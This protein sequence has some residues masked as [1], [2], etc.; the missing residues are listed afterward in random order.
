MVG[1]HALAFHAKPRFTKDLDVLVEATEENARRVLSALA[2]F[3]FGSVDLSVEDL[4]VPGK[5]VQ[6]GYPPNRIDLLTSIA[7]VDFAEAWAGRA[8]GRY[9]DAEVHY[10]GRAE[11]IRNKRAAARPQDL[12]DLS[13]LEA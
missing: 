9:G 13:W 8:M 1:A 11:L 7:G 6:L 4:A 3:G 5:V 10:L 2:D 12:V